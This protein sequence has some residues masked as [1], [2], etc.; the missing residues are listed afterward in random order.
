MPPISLTPANGSGNKAY[1]TLPV[2]ATGR[3]G[4]TNAGFRRLMFTT[5]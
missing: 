4:G 5:R 1:L 2:G 3:S